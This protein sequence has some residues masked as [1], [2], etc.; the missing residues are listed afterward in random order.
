MYVSGAIC[1]VAVTGQSVSGSIEGGV[2]MLG[3]V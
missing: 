3:A 2:G 1:F